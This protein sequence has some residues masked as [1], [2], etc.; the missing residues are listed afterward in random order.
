MSVYL[1]MQDTAFAA[2]AFAAEESESVTLQQHA[3][4]AKAQTC[5]DLLSSW[6]HSICCRPNAQTSFPTPVAVLACVGA[7]Q[8]EH[9]S[10]LKLKD[11]LCAQDWLL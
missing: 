9:E 4:V 11:L 7:D 1:T 8:R 2:V 10:V 6:Q 3:Q 5:T